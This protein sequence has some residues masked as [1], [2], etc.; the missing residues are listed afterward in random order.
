MNFIET[1]IP[2]VYIIEP[3]IFG[4]NRGYFYESYSQ[5]EFDEH[6][7]PIQF[8]QD[9]QS[10]SVKNVVRGLHYQK[11]PYAQSKLVRCPKGKVMDIAVDI[12]KYSPT[13]RQFVMVELS[14]DN[15]RQL[16][17]PQGFAHG[18]ITLSDEAILQYKCDNFYNKDADAGISILDESLGLNI[19][20][21]VTELIMSEKDMNQPLLDDNKLDFIYY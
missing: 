13:Y 20:E 18:F 19:S 12:R 3:K 10:K 9:N 7:R 16:F 2:G 17:I 15:H 1:K 8:V 11:L 21:Y 6:I 5:R 14:E 4:D